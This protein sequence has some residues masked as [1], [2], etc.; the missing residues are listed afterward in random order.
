MA[1]IRGAFMMPWDAIQRFR[2]YEAAVRQ[3]PIE[4]VQS[5]RRTARQSLLIPWESVM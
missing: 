2:Q 4:R 5:R 1:K 3:V